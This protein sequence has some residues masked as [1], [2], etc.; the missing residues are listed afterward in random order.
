MVGRKTDDLQH[1]SR[2]LERRVRKGE[3][4]RVEVDKINAALPDVSKKGVEI[5]EK[6]LMRAAR[7]AAAKRRELAAKAPPQPAYRLPVPVTSFEDEEY[8]ESVPPPDDDD[9][10]E[11][12]D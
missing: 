10:A 11:D 5:D 7:E 4:A 12:D 3:L 8:F 2:L 9:D 6:A 1:D